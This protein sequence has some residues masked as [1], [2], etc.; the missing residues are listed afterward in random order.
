MEI[1]RNAPLVAEHRRVI[2]APRSW[3]WQL[4]TMIDSWAGWHPG[5]SRAALVG[6]LV[7][8][9]VFRWASG[10]MGI[11]S[12]LQLVE[13]ERRFGWTGKALGTFTLH[14]WHLE[15]FAGGTQVTTTESMEGWLIHPLKLLSPR[16]LDDALEAWL[17]G[18]AAAAE[19][20]FTATPAH[21]AHNVHATL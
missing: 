2:Q 12:T 14:I 8:G 3:V 21:P 11:V 19:A 20:P 9:S 5:I 15:D 16:F 17:A 10:G 1:N 7:P 4:L 18:L 6:P 13:P